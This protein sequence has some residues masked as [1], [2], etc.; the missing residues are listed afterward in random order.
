VSD[1]ETEPG[2]SQPATL[3]E[4]LL[5]PVEQHDDEGNVMASRMTPREQLV[6][7]GLGFANVAIVAATASGV[8]EQQALVVLAGLVASAMSVVGAR[9]GNRL[10]AMAGLFGCTLLRP[11]STAIFFALV[12]PYYGAFL[13]MF[14]KY[15]RLTKAKNLRIR[16]QRQEARAAARSGSATPSSRTPAGKGK[17]GTG[18]KPRPT[19]SKRYTPPKAKRRPPTPSKPPPDRSIVD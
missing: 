14:L 19:A 4:R 15:N 9:V 11:G 3:L 16:Q 7:A 13:W 5:P 10:L 6:A 12:F 1:E 17:A 2:T 18:A 8:K